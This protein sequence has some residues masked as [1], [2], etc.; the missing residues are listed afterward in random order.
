MSTDTN[1]NELLCAYCLFRDKGEN[2]N[3]PK[4][5][6]VISGMA[7]CMEHT[8]FLTNPLFSPVIKMIM[9]IE[10]KMIGLKKR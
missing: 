3:A 4:A 6:T 8:G 5:V 9:D 2:L 1:T 10:F 7:L